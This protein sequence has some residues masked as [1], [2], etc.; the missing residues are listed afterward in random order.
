MKNRII[1]TWYC[2][3]LLAPEKLIFFRSTK[4]KITK[5]CENVPHLKFTERVLVHCNIIS[6]DYQNDLKVFYIVVPN[7]FSWVVDILPENFIFSKIFN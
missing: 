5:D 7:E 2:L 3:E 4:N 6:N 1:K